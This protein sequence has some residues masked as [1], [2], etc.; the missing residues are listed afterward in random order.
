[1]L[2]L[3]LGPSAALEI[4]EE[5]RRSAARSRLIERFDPAPET[6][7]ALAVFVSDGCHV[8]TALE[9][10]IDV[11]A[12]RS[13]DRGATLFDEG[14]DA[15]AWRELGDPG[16]PVRGRPRPR[17]ASCSPRGPSTTSPSSR[18]SSRPPS[19]GAPSAGWRRLPVS[20][21]DD[22]RVGRA[23]ESLAGDT[24]RRGFLA[25][26]GGAMTAVDRRRRWSR[27][28]SSPATPTPS[29]SAATPTRPAPA[30]PDGPALPR[31]DHDGYPL[32]P[33]DGQPIDNLGRPVNAR[34]EPVDDKGKTAARPRRTPAAAGA[35]DQICERDRASA[36]ASAPPSTAAG[37]AAATDTCASS[38]TAART[39]SSGSTAT[40]R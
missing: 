6:Q 21:R 39:S 3:R 9:P 40:R 12:R 15:A 17:R 19:A 31:I 18:A 34:G 8:C 35:A 36:T 4:A 26:V 33:S 20:D 2:R 5:G 22:E 30:P 27:A 10:A 14:E 11:V 25:R 23:L 1:M 37:T 38:W 29:T 16:Q 24:S 32:R 13:A 28:R 7:L